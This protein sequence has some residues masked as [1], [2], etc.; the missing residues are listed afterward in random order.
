M[1]DFVT[2]LEVL[3][4][5]GV[6][7][8]HP[9][10]VFMSDDVDPE[11]I[12]TGVT[13]H[14]GCRIQGA[15]TSIGPGSVIG[16]EGPATVIDCQLGAR[17][18]LKG[19]YFEGSV[20]LDDV[21]VG[22]AA[23]VRPGCLLEE[24]ACAAHAVG[25]KQ[26]ILFPFVTLGSL[27][28][29]CDILMSGGTSRKNHSEVGSSFIHFNFTPHGDKATASLI[30]EVSRGVLLN[31]P[32]IFLGGQ[33]GIVGPVEMAFGTVQA[34]GSICRRDLLEA[35]HLYQSAVSNERYVPYQ[36]GKLRDAEAKWQKNLKYIA[37]LRALRFWYTDFR[38]PVMSGD[39]STRAC[40]DGAVALLDGAVKERLKQLE[41]WVGI[42]GN[43]TWQNA[44]PSLREALAQSADVSS[45]KALCGCLD[46]ESAP[47]MP[48]TQ[49]IQH[50]DADQQ[51]C[52]QQFFEQEIN[53]LTVSAATLEG[54]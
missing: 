44:L 17:V 12:A 27:I 48:Y 43:L 36:T 32:P 20:F 35:D 23:H 8:P 24:E 18:S 11:R 19:G 1:S 25:L 45:I 47:D 10:S 53:R 9:Q 6:K 14:P 37:S 40:L 21:S 42:S 13:L 29:F 39:I 33:G 4:E 30:G 28:N 26:T 46:L 50:L 49:R 31:Q 38:M 5:R 7:I 51:A 52:V 41:K 3:I 16:E 34:A 22:S 2:Q 15:S 54:D